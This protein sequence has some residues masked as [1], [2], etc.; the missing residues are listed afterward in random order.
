MMIHSD[1]LVQVYVWNHEDNTKRAC[2]RNKER[3]YKHL[4]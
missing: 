3:K 1:W 4:S 2:K